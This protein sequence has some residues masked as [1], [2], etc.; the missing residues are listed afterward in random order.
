MSK[1]LSVVFLNVLSI[2]YV[3]KKK[4]KKKSEEGYVYHHFLPREQFYSLACFQHM[5]NPGLISIECVLIY[6]LSISGLLYDCVFV[7]SRACIK[8]YI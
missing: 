7:Y 2:E 5:S 8:L 1:K 6:I 3:Q 4:K